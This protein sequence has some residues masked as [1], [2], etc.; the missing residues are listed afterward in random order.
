M[1]NFS[2]YMPTKV[3]FG[4][5][6]VREAGANLALGKKALIVTGS[7]SAKRSGALDDVLAVLTTEYVLFDQVE[8]NPSVETVVKGGRLAQEEGCDFVIAIGG[9][10]PLDAAKVIAILAVNGGNPLDFYTAGWEKRALPLVAIPTTAGTGSEVTQYAVLTV[11]EEETKKGL[12][13]P[14]LFPQVAYI[15]P[16]YT[17]SLT[18]E[19]TIDTAV[20]A[21]S[22][23]VEGY[24]SKR[25]TEASDLVSLQGIALWGT[26]KEDLLQYEITDKTRET[27]LLAST[28]G[29]VTIAQTGTTLVHALGYPLTYYHAFPH[30]RAN[31]VLMTEY[32]RFTEKVAPDRVATILELLDLP[33]IDAFGALLDTLFVEYVGTL[34][35]SE[36]ILQDYA[37]RATLTRNI[38]NSLGDPTVFELIQILKFSLA[39]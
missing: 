34:T 38:V 3:V 22:H 7:T 6:V 16:K 32:L 24:L 12:G 29:G 14:D 13:G 27:L 19:V 23:L 30:G 20:D 5:N 9:G 37:E 33:S 18:L 2:F 39:R 31:A 8:N 36:Q 11:A 10:S 26:V 4:H 28:L 17:S 1:Q 35:L 25:A 21:L 15:D